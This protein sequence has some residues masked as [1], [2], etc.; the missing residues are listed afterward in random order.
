M[1]GRNH[2]DGREHVGMDIAKEDMQSKLIR[3]NWRGFCPHIKVSV[4]RHF[5]KP[6]G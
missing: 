6:V 3:N 5:G 4:E 1:I 2:D